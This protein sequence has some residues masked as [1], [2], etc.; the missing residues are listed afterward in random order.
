MRVVNLRIIDLDYCPKCHGIFFDK[1]EFAFV[2]QRTDINPKDL[3]L[4]GELL[5]NALFY[6]GGTQ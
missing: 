3:E 4:V 1:G 5:I 2:S 6:T